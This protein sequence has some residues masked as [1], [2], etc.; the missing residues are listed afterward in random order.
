MVIYREISLHKTRFPW[1]ARS[2]S[3][4][5][6]THREGRTLE[7]DS[8]IT[9]SRFHS[10][11]KRPNDIS[12]RLTDRLRQHACANTTGLFPSSFFLSLRLSRRLTL[13][14]CGVATTALLRRLVREYLRLIR[15]R[16]PPLPFLPAGLSTP[17]YRYIDR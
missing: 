6:Q 15:P 12:H 16:C 3:R 10:K 8:A 2:V 7:H 11:F 4:R 9:R 13:T 14:R 17:R 5:K 1:P